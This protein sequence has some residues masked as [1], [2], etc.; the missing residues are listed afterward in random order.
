MPIVYTPV[1]GEACIKYSELYKRP[2]GLFITKHDRGKRNVVSNQKNIEKFNWKLFAGH[3]YDIL[4]NWP[5]KDIKAIVVT[6]GERIL[7]LGDLGANGMGIPVGK[8][9]LYSALAGIPPHSTLPVTLDVGTNNEQLIDSETY[10]GLKEKRERGKLYDE[11]VEEF[12]EAAV[13]K[14]GRSCLIQFEDFGNSNA[15]K[16]L[17]RYRNNYCTFND[18][19]QA[20]NLERQLKSTS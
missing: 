14:W 1:V 13:K 16:L 9:A 8:L 20:R 15:F 3:V 5:E 18:D 12:M 2:R 11:L 4:C 19:I 17:D 10:I 6:D 7:G